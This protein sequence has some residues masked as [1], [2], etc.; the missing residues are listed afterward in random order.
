MPTD[1]FSNTVT[2]GGAFSAEGATITFDKAYTG[3][4]V[5][6]LS[7]QYMQNI[8]RLYD[9]TSTDI[10]L[11]SGRTQGQGSMS[12]VMGPSALAA[13][14]FT[15]YGNVCYSETN[16]LTISALAECHLGPGAGESQTITLMM[17]HVV[18]NSYG[19]AISAQDMVV[20]E[21]LGF[22][23]LWMTYDVAGG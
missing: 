17:S 21:Q 11:V 18:L 4:L 22:I 5:Q 8:T 9:V 19:G 20:N 23:Y 6:N 13:A 2:Y 15:R 16:T 1:M 10:V 14:F 12:R 7:W 3:L